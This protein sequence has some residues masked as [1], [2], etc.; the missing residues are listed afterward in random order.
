MTGGKLLRLERMIPAYGITVKHKFPY[1][2]LFRNFMQG[3]GELQLSEI[4]EKRIAISCL[5]L[6]FEK[7]YPTVFRISSATY[8]LP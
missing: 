4:S 7:F 8:I 5:N 3:A 1:A 2:C 6:K